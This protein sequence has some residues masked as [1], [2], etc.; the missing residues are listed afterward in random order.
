MKSTIR[1][2]A[3]RIHWVLE[4]QVGISFKRV[5]HAFLSAPKY[6]RHLREYRRFGKDEIRLMPC[7][8]DWRVQSGESSSEYFWQDLL[9]AQLINRATPSR[10]I[11]IGSR[12]DG[13]VTH[14]ASYREIEVLDVR[15][16]SAGIP[17]VVFRQLDFSA[18]LPN[19][20]ERCCDSVS[21]LHTLEHF[22]L[23]RYGDPIDPDAWRA[24]ITN[25][26]SLLEQNG[27][28]YLSTPVGLPRVEFNAHRVFDVRILLGAAKDERLRIERLFL[29]DC[30][31]FNEVRP[32]QKTLNEITLTEYQL[33][34]VE[35]IKE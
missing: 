5:V 33:I 2:I 1:N 25:L 14:V 17:N 21:C 15:P 7:L 20:Y 24:G 26:S 28:L 29:V 19:E 10:H 12:I 30:H 34:L 11:D 27:R 8:H 18:P 31:G 22:G 4:A 6:M 16:L 13:F 9:V 32:E 3:L 35:F 23:G